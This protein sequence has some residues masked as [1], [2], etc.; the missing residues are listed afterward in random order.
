[1]MLPELKICGVRHVETLS[2]LKECEVN[3]VGFVFAPSKRSVSLEQAKRLV[4]HSSN[5][6]KTVGVLVNEEKIRLEE[7]L[8]LGLDVIQ[9]HGSESPE[10]CRRIRQTGCAVWKA[11]SLTS[12]TVDDQEKSLQTLLNKISTYAHTI[13]AVLLDTKVKGQFGGTG[14]TFDWSVIP[15]VKRELARMNLPLIVAGGIDTQNIAALLAAYR[16]DGIDVSSGVETAGEK[17]AQKIR[18]LSEHVHSVRKIWRGD[19]HVKCAE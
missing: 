9:C 10:T 7:I 4:Q 8:R 3:Y 14:K 16:P 11:F 19:Q 18:R 2:V 1:M 13:D 17:D 15:E 5:R 6:L 12:G